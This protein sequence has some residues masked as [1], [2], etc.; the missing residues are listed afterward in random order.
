M[1]KLFSKMMLVALAA[2]AFTACEDVPEPYDI[3]Q[4]GNDDTPTE[5]EGETGTGTKTDP[6]NA[7]AAINYGNKLQSGEESEDYYYIKGKIVSIK[8]EYTTQYGN[9]TFYIS[10]DGSANNQFYV[11]RALYLG[12]KKFASGD[13][14]IKIGDEVIICGKITNY[15]GTIETAQNK[16][17]LYQL[18]EENRGGEPDG[19]GT[20]AGDAKGDGS[21]ENPFNSIAAIA[22]AK[23]VG[24]TES[25]KDVYIKGKVASITEQYGTQFGNAS[26]TIS[27]D[28][29]ANGA[30]TV[31]R[32]LYLGNQKYT[33]GDLL[34]EGNEVIV[35]G[36]VTNFKGNTP[37][38]VQG[39]AYLYS[40]NGNTA[41]GGDEPGEVKTVGSVD[42]PQ[43]IAQALA[44]IDKLA[45]NATTDE[46]YYVKGKISKINTTGDNVAKYKNIN[47]VISDG[48]KDLTIYQGRNLNDTDFTKDGEINVDDEVVVFGQLQRFVNN[49]GNM[50]PE[51]AKG[52]YIVKLT[53]GSSGNPDDNPTSGSGSGT[54][55]DPYDAVAAIAYTQSLG[56]D[57]ES[58][59]DIYVKGIISSIKYTYSA[60]YGTATYAIS[61][62]GNAENEFTV[63]GSYYFDNKPWVDGNIQI[64]KGDKVI[65][66]GKV[67]YY[68]GN[69]PEFANKKNW[70]VS[71]NDKTSDGGGDNNGGDNNG[72]N[73]GGGGEVSGNTLTV[74]YG[75]LGISSLDNAITLADGTK[76]TFAQEGGKNPPIYHESTKIIRMYA[77]NS[78]TINAGSKKIASVAFAYDTY[79]G[80]AY[81]GNDEMFG[82]AGGNKITPT[83]DDKNVTFAGVNNSTLKVVN[84]FSSNSG[85]TQFRCTG[86][87][88]TYAE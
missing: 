49:S 30:F 83:K 44:V 55:D 36:K 14:Q 11:Y 82:E 23:E 22:Y 21:L 69:T 76:L 7:V 51:M 80:T 59:S 45:D 39:K 66:C 62:D 56:A 84:D 33:S 54:K 25:P 65:V 17:F 9:G 63:Y 57:V 42:N 5:I 52:N 38:T 20:P 50:V 40:L 88:I 86:L 46:W 1:K 35:C 64:Q 81:K 43:T 72:G 10:S 41:S 29:T 47:Y 75:D 34:E 48:G 2:L 58:S 6:F 67:V 31:Y 24:D 13:T 8:E 73:N 28:G 16:G 68:M 77:Q 26:F 74:V 61:V 27:D 37:E 4:K 32:A 79:N 18:N 3:P 60:Q 53:A 87:T 78:V 19:G 71:I 70:L 85:G 15:N 12:N